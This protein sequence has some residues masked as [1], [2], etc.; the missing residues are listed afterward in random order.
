MLKG[1]EKQEIRCFCHVSLLCCASAKLPAS[2]GIEMAIIHLTIT[3]SQLEN[4]IAFV[5]DSA[6]DAELSCHSP[7]PVYFPLTVALPLTV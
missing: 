5:H 7:L 2:T 1:T 3:V 6:A 4:D